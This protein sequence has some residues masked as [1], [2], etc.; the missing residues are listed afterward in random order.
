MLRGLLERHVIYTDY[1]RLK[2]LKLQRRLYGTL[3]NF[4]MYTSV[5]RR[6]ETFIEKLENT[7]TDT[8]AGSLILR[9]A[10]ASAQPDTLTVF[11]RRA[12]RRQ[13][14]RLIGDPHRQRRTQRPR[15]FLVHTVCLK[16]LIAKSRGISR[17]TVKHTMV[18]APRVRQIDS[19]T[20]TQSSRYSNSISVKSDRRYL[21]F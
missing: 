19:P 16:G 18:A 1:Y 6:R 10:S 5:Y 4:F 3:I 9:S 11:C 13:E 15:L 8:D 20:F 2:S 14:R 17:E 12:Y 7:G 21:F